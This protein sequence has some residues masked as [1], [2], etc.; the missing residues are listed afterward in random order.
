MT[1]VDRTRQRVIGEKVSDLA[2]LG[3]Q[4]ITIRYISLNVENVV[5]DEITDIC[6][7]YEYVLRSTMYD[8][9]R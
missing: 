2:Q 4:R 1:G 8:L 6:T 7:L 5:V 3:V 9:V